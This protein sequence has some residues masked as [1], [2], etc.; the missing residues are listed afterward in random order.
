MDRLTDRLSGGKASDDDQTEG[1]SRTLRD[2]VAGPRPLIEHAQAVPLVDALTGLGTAAALLVR[3]D[4]EIE[5]CRRYDTSFCVLFLDVE[6]L[7]ELNLQHG[8]LVADAL[9]AQAGRAIDRMLRSGDFVAHWA[10]GRFAALMQGPKEQVLTGTAR[11]LGAVR[12]LQPVV[13]MG[14]RPLSVTAAMGGVACPPADPEVEMTPPALI[15]AARGMLMA[16]KAGGGEEA[17]LT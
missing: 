2:E 8:P 4:Q 16:A 10:G 13:R 15:K 5:R 7:W 17:L 6:N 14:D 9:I 1:D 11:I 3:L 12:G